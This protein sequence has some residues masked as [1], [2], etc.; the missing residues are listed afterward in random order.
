ML[1]KHAKNQLKKSKWGFISAHY[2]KKWL[3][4]H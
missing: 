2:V 4:L 1:V 3:K